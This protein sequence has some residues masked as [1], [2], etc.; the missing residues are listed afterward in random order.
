MTDR[1]QLTP[2]QYSVKSAYRIDPL[3]AKTVEFVEF[4][5]CRI[6]GEIDAGDI[7]K[8]RH[9]NLFFRSPSFLAAIAV[10]ATLIIC[11]PVLKSNTVDAVSSCPTVKIGDS[12]ES[13]A[14]VQYRLREFGWSVQVDG[15][16]G[17]QTLRAIIRFQ[18]MSGLSADGV[19]G[20]VTQRALGCGRQST[21]QEQTQSAAH[22]YSVSSPAS[23]W[24]DLA[25]SVGW[26]EHKLPFVACVIARESNGIPSAYNGRNRDRSYGLLQLNTK[27]RLWSWY[28]ARGLTSKDQLFDPSTNLRYG[29]LLWTQYPNAWG[30]CR[31]RG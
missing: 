20:S 26:P 13:V 15:Q 2:Y 11:F 27:G 29:F 12:G 7:W 31:P 22:S 9:R 28:T 10:A 23:S 18:Q 3:L 8:R 1:I 30:R 25:R 16:F 14:A 19:V 4:R 6:N 17:P 5:P 24:I 21:N